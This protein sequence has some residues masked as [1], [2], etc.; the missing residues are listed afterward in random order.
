M[1]LAGWRLEFYGF[2]GTLQV[3]LMSP[4]YRLF[5]R[6]AVKGMTPGWHSW[7]GEGAAGVAASLLPD[8]AYQAQITH[9]LSRVR[10]NDVADTRKRLY[11]PEAVI[12]IAGAV[13]HSATKQA[14]VPVDVETLS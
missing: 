5:I 13:F 14:G 12:A 9:V 2:N 8:P 3:G 6:D 1:G 10:A 4:W 11:D 7:K